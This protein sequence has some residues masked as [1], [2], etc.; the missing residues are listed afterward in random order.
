MIPPFD[1]LIAHAESKL[2]AEQRFHDAKARA[3]QRIHKNRI[4]RRPLWRATIALSVAMKGKQIPTGIC[5]RQDAWAWLQSYAAERT[6]LQGPAA[7]VELYR[8]CLLPAE[9]RTQ[10]LMEIRERRER[11]DRAARRAHAAELRAQLVHLEALEAHE[12]LPENVIP[13][14]RVG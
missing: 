8:I 12:A 2:A 4:D 10:L 7:I 3:G 13:L 6:G 5:S 1:A 14:R 9:E 11:R